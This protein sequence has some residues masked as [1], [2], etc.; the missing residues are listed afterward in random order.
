MEPWEDIT[1]NEDAIEER[2][3]R[4]QGPGGQHVN[5]SSTAVQLRFDTSRSGLSAPVRRKLLRIAGSRATEEGVI[6]IE[7]SEHR[8]QA[9]NR[10]E[11]RARLIEWIREAS[12]PVKSRRPT[13]PTKASKQRRIT[14]KRRKGETK[15]LRGG[16]SRGGDE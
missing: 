5:T 6:L 1:L 4:S 9:R 12:R 8:S 3:V 11:A 2:F 14:E 16:P 15:R 13:R 10:E 7:A